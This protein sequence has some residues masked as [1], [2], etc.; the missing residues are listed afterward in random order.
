MG[1]GGDAHDVGDWFLAFW[2][3]PHPLDK[4]LFLGFQGGK[5]NFSYE[6]PVLFLFA[7]CP[8][9]VLETPL[10]IEKRPKEKAS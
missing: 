8:G 5:V 6:A 2:P 9:K 1:K 7:R 3:A 10:P 4:I